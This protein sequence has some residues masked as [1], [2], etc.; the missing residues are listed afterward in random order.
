MGKPLA[1]ALLAAALSGC[2]PYPEGASAPEDTAS[3]AIVTAPF[4]SLDPGASEQ[5]SL[6]FKV[7]AYGADVARQISDQAEVYYQRIMVDTN[8]FSF[9]PS[10]LYQ[11]VVYGSQDEYRRK[12]NQPAWSGGVSYGNSIYSF[13]GGQL[14]QTI[15]HEMTHL[16]FFEF[17]GRSDTNQR[18]VNEGL[19]VY[20]EAKAAGAANAPADLFYAIRS[21][22]RV[23][24]LTLDQMI[25]LVPAS[26]KERTVSLWYAE[27]ESLVQFM[28][29][30]GGRLGFSQFLQGLKDGKNFDEA[31]GSGFVGVWRNLG[32]LYQTWQTSIQ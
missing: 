15:A 25:H 32:D 27:S 3:S 13:V 21:T 26:E 5:M 17:M 24:P 31:I 23:Q 10:G 28:I 18:W 22:L 9:M 6:H 2:V 14:N 29:E 11:I 12:T 8:L 4:G 30:R 7:H 19:A 16:I 20:E 1:I